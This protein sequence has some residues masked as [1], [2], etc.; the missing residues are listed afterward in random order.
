M[1]TPFPSG[2]APFDAVRGRHLI[3]GALTTKSKTLLRAN[4]QRFS[5]S[6][7]A[8]P[9]FAPKAQTLLKVQRFSV[10]RKIFSTIS[11][12]TPIF[13]RLA[14]STRNV[15]LDE[16]LNNVILIFKARARN[17][18]ASRRTHSFIRRDAARFARRRSF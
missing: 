9:L 4:A 3:I 12:K 5:P 14:R 6:T 11:A 18:N 17:A 15:L 2:D 13:R 7:Q 10:E 8:G 16:S 1:K